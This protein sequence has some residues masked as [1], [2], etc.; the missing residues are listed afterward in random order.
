MAASIFTGAVR[1]ASG[2]CSIDSFTE[3]R[4]G[5]G[6]SGNLVWM[7]TRKEKQDD[8]RSEVCC[9]IPCTV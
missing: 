7:L 1:A 8:L 2:Q 4:V 6:G 9:A 5:A 3:K